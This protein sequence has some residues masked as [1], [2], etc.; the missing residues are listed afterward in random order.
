MRRYIT[1]G[2]AKD[3]GYKNEKND[4][5]V[6]ALSIA[7]GISYTKAYEKLDA[8]GRKPNKGFYIIDFFKHCTFKGYEVEELYWKKKDRLTEKQFA[9]KYPKGNW[10]IYTESHVVAV[11]DGTIF[12]TKEEPAEGKVQYAWRLEKA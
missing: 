6:V 7:L 10:I 8:A 9:K 3:A 2:G 1:D 4:C 12:D 5:A 11:V